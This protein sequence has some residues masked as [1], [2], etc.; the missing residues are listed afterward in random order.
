M[1]WIAQSHGTDGADH[2]VLGKNPILTGGDNHISGLELFFVDDVFHVRL[3]IATASN[4]TMRARN[5]KKSAHSA[6]FVIDE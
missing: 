1:K 4:D 5:G 6:V 3:G 2:Q